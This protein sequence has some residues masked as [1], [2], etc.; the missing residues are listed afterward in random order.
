MA[1]RQRQI[2]VCCDG[3]NNT[4]TGQVKD[5]N[6]LQLF[7][8]VRVERD[9]ERQPGEPP[10]PETV[11]YYDPGVGSATG[12]PPTGVTG[13]VT[14]GLRRAGGL[15]L[16]SGIYENIGEAYLHLCREYGRLDLEAGRGSTADEIWLFGFSRGAFTVRAVA[17]MVSLFGLIRPEHH[18]LLPTLLRTYFAPDDSSSAH[19][20]PDPDDPDHPVSAAMAPSIS[21]G[22]ATAVTKGMAVMNARPRVMADGAGGKLSR[23]KVAAQIRKDFT[24]P[25]GRSV[26]IHFLGVWDTVE[27]VGILPGSR[28]RISTKPI[29]VG[30]PYRHVRQAL[31]LDEHRRQFRPRYFDGVIRSDQTLRQRWFRGVHS[32]IGGNRPVKGS[33]LSWESFGWMADEARACG[34]RMKPVTREPSAA[35]EI[36]EVIGDQLRAQ[37]S[38][39]LTGMFLRDPTDAVGDGYVRP[40]SEPKSESER[41]PKSEP[42]PGQGSEA[43]PDPKRPYTGP[44]EHESVERFTNPGSSEPGIPGSP[45]DPGNGP[46]K[47]SIL[48]RWLLA[49]GIGWLSLVAAGALATPGPADTQLWESTE[50]GF[51]LFRDQI[52]LFWDSRPVAGDLP[53]SGRLEPASARFEAWARSDVEAAQASYGWAQLFLLGFVCSLAAVL[54]R[55]PARA[56]GQITR[57]R[58]LERRISSVPYT[59]TE[60]RRAG[61]G[62]WATGRWYPLPGVVPRRW[63]NV[64]F[65]AVGLGYAVMVLAFVVQTITLVIAWDVGRSSLRWPLLAVASEANVVASVGAVLTVVLLVWW[66]PVAAWTC[67]R[68][69]GARLARVRARMRALAR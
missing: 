42:E 15:A 22:V 51:H 25:I 28:K 7:E 68:Q 27:S 11:L 29:I 31:A 9:R 46:R 13:L 53:I 14:E 55:I 60:H 26:E 33:L 2:V 12:L 44:V 17:G 3:T 69:R 1:S 52:S 24:T 41:E 21:A 34:L 54:A 23:S 66:V 16:G 43:E 32:D 4:L 65:E 62:R 56:F 5:T 20:S 47:R 30:N 67:W 36:V 37:P 57:W 8:R 50:A 64:L 10:A 49:G 19:G 35:A 18:V 38:W 45:W 39:V 63:A 61:P 58:R 6:V 40:E 59:G 48:G